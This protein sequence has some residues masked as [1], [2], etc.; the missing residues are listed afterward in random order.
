MMT[1]YFST[2]Y[3]LS[4]KYISLHLHEF[5]RVHKFQEVEL[6]RSC[7]KQTDVCKFSMLMILFDNFVEVD[8]LIKPQL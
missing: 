6:N 3:F 1:M 8:V 2:V 5:I 7:P 4:I